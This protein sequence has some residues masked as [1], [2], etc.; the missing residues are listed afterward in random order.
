M[1]SY[2]SDEPKEYGGPHVSVN[3]RANSEELPISSSVIPMNEFCVLFRLQIKIRS[4]FELI[5]LYVDKE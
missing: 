4:F 1:A 3:M 2:E 5:S